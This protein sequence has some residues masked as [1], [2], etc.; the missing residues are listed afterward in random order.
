ML[1]KLSI[2]PHTVQLMTV[3]ACIFYLLKKKSFQ[4]YR[5]FSAAWIIILLYDLTMV[6]IGLVYHVNNNHWVYNIAFPLQ[7]FFIMYFFYLLSKSKKIIFVICLFGLFVV[8]NLVLWQGRVTLNTYSLA[9]GGVIILLFAFYKLYSLYRIDTPESLYREPAFWI[10]T[11]FI[12]YWGMASPFFA[13]YN[14]LWKTVPGF[15]IIY[16]YTVNFGFTILLNL[17]IIKALQ[18]SLKTQR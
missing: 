11:G 2:I 3:I 9:L 17:S 4:P 12:I 7:Q 5:F 10:C 6:I 13:V 15:F 8:F 16:F 1:V 18:C 14:F